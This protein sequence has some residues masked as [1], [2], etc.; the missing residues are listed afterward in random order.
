MANLEY[1]KKIGGNTVAHAMQMASKISNERFTNKLL[2][3]T[4]YVAFYLSGS[5]HA[6]LLV[7]MQ[8]V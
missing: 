8:Y 5:G 6:Q 2:T 4:E 3:S 1:A 7:R